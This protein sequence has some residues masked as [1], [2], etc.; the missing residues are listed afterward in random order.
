MMNYIKNLNIYLESVERS[1]TRL[2]YHL[3]MGLKKSNKF[4][5]KNSDFSRELQLK[6][7]EYR[8]FCESYI[9][10]IRSHTEVLK[11]IMSDFPIEEVMRLIKLGVPKAEICR[12]YEIT[13]PTLQRRISSAESILVSREMKED[14]KN[15]QGI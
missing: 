10:Y 14:L 12:R 5:D 15:G 1:S 6:T 7:N 11:Q 8:N 4:T 3:I 2:Q 13:F 9:G